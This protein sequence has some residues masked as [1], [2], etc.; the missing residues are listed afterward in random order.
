MV[1]GVL[2]SVK[3]MVW[4]W[5][6]GLLLLWIWGVV[7]TELIGYTDQFHDNLLAQFY[8]GDPAKSMLTLFQVMTVDT[9][10]EL[11]A[12]PILRENFYL[13][14]FFVGYIIIGLFVYW[15]LVIGIVVD[16]AFAQ[17]KAD[18]ELL[19]MEVEARK[20]KTFNKLLI[21]F[22][23]AD[24]DGSGELSLAEF[25][26]IAETP[27]VESMLKVLELSVESLENAWKFMIDDEDGL[28]TPQEFLAGIKRM[29]GR[30]KAKDVKELFHRISTISSSSDRLQH[31]VTSLYSS[32]HR[33]EDETAKT[34][35]DLREVCGLFQEIHIRLQN[36]SKSMDKKDEERLAQREKVRI[37][38]LKNEVLQEPDDEE[39]EEEEL[40]PKE[41]DF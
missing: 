25:K 26:E 4:I 34:S 8:F 3:P 28:L 22:L 38:S 40:A 12:R 16:N 6:M 7:A 36:Q 24:K 37:E 2:S 13:A 9:W 33:L 19:A 1:N 30:A 20:S 29:Q 14:L 39:D 35:N 27:E 15:N 23:D 18:H 41:A 21:F 32:L 10:T 11:I 17:T 31:K 5:V